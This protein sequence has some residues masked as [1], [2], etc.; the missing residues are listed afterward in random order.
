MC[1]NKSLLLLLSILLFTSACAKKTETETVQAHYY[2]ACHEPLAYLHSRT[3]GTTGKAIASGAI[4]GG[5]ISGIASAI[6]GAITGNLRPVGVLAGVAAGGAVGGLV[7]GVN[8]HQVS[9][10]ED[11]QHLSKYLE[12]VDGDISNMDIVQAAATVSKQ[13][14][15]KEFTALTSEMR[16]GRI[17]GS[18]AQARYTEI[19]AGTKEADQLLGITPDLDSMLKDFD[20]AKR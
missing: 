8:Q 12:E 4:Q 2:P 5:V 10:R 15:A 20:A 7:G 11:N 1:S 18:A 16:Q 17:E 14:Y 9:E 13:C 19:A 6:I 3:A